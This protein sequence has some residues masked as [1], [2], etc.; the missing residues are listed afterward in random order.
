MRLA[1]ELR[2]PAQLWLTW[3]YR[4][5]FALLEGDY[6]RAEETIVQEA[7]QKDAATPV[8]DDVSALRMHWFLLRREQGRVAEEEANVRASVDEFPW[9]PLHRS[10]LA[11][12]LLDAGR[13]DEARVV[14]DEMAVDE[15]R[16][17]YPDCEWMLGI[18]LA[19]EACAALGDASAA[20]ILYRQLLP[21]A[22]SH[23]NG[24]T[25]GSI[26]S[27]D[28]YLGLLAATMGTY[29]D[30]ER[31]L[32]AAIAEN[33][34]IGAWPWA[35]HARHD[36][37]RALARRAGPGDLERADALERAALATAR[38]LGMTALEAA[39][40]GG[41]EPVAGEPE[42]P[43]SRATFRRE[44]EYWTVQ[45]DGDPFRIRDMKGM[46][47]LA[48]LLA[49]PGRELHALDLAGAARPGGMTTSTTTDELSADPFADAGPV[50]DPEA[51][52]AYAQRLAEL[53]EELDQATSWNDPE[54]A[55]R[56]SSEID[57]LTHELAAAV[58][59]GG[60]ERVASS[61][62][63]RARLSVTRAIRAAVSRIGEQ[64]PALG[65]HLD[66]TVR[67]GTFCSYV[68]DPRVPITWEL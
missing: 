61:S 24:H 34:R 22:G 29:A 13:T 6:A 65:S 33:E 30:A 15:F 43:S 55:A 17:H 27:V 57:A 56:A 45:F 46:R 10:A 68:P 2:Q 50:L 25:E 3:A 52:A 51:R 4:S 28:R 60:R 36:L 67:T 26:G 14:F 38:R 9:Y 64:S 66:A 59:L 44:G 19:A 58:G 49:E 20:A 53:R 21:F 1:G 5:I 41:H 48:R 62:A 12:L 47:H 32:D 42:R 23:A 16:M 54:R 37:A 35:A 7:E 11:C 63:E 8:R 18:P 40:G 31:H 39:I